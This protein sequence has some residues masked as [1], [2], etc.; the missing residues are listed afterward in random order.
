METSKIDEVEKISPALLLN[1]CAWEQLNEPNNSQMKSVP[2]S[3]LIN[4]SGIL[5]GNLGGGPCQIASCNCYSVN[6]NVLQ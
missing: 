1:N 4:Y 5:F 6:A 2:A 3:I